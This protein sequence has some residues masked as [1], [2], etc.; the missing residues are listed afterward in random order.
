MGEWNAEH[1]I[2]LWVIGGVA[3]IAAGSYPWAFMLYRLTTARINAWVHEVLYNHLVHVDAR[4][5]R[6]E[7]RA[8]VNDEEHKQD[9]MPP[10]W[11]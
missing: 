4:L 2:L 8:D 1:Q 7:G 11:Q 6:L 3:A 5:A 9:S 10:K